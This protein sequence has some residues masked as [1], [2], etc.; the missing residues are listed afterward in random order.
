L[1][2]RFFVVDNQ[3]IFIDRLRTLRN[4]KNVSQKQVAVGLNITETGYQNYEVGRRKPTFEMLIALA[5]FFDV[6]I[7]YLVGRT[8]TPEVN[9]R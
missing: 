6:S 8:D 4:E 5:D 1:L 9:R 7:D 3:K 2:R